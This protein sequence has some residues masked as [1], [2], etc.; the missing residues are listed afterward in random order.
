MNVWWLT[1][2][3]IPI[4]GEIFGTFKWLIDI[5]LLVSHS[6]NELHMQIHESEQQIDDFWCY[7]TLDESFNSQGFRNSFSPL[8]LSA[9]KT[10]SFNSGDHPRNSLFF[11][12]MSS[13]DI[14]SEFIQ[15]LLIPLRYTLLNA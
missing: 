4:K 3:S 8:T 6:E 7:I 10:Q 9:E 1:V 14:R 5:A 12:L 13:R 11:S 2:R 15:N